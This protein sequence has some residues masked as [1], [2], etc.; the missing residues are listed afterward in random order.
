MERWISTG[1]IVQ[2]CIRRWIGTGLEEW[3][4]FYQWEEEGERAKSSFQA[5]GRA[6]S[7]SD[8]LMCPWN[9]VSLRKKD[10]QIEVIS[11]GNQTIALL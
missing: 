9:L 4:R 1:E 7:A 10:K 8:A 3:V 2:E 5:G 11:G 6:P